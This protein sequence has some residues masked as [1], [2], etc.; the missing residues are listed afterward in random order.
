MTAAIR[1]EAE[2]DRE[3]IWNVNQAAFEGDY[4]AN[5]VDALRGGGFVEMSLVAEVVG[6][7]VG[8]I[9]F[10]RVTIVTNVGTVDALSL[11]PMAVLPSHQRQGIGSRLVEEGLE[12]CRERGHRFVVVLGHPEFYPRFEFSSKLAERLQSPFGGG[13]AWMALELVPGAL[14][15]IEGRVEYSPPFMSLE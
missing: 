11:A 14:E 7:I 3:A 8:H 5:L 6:E 13:E 9:L 1:P 2:Q 15:G 10:S 12:A 4:E